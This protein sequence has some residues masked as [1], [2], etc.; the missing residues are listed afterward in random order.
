MAHVDLPWGPL[1]VSRPQVLQESRLE[2]SPCDRYFVEQHRFRQPLQPPT[3]P[4]AD[5]NPESHLRPCPD[6]FRDRP[7]QRFLQKALPRAVADLPCRGKTAGEFHQAVIE[8]G[9]AGFQG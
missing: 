2:V 3:E 1:E 7:F 9:G 4:C 8:K 6:T 5:G